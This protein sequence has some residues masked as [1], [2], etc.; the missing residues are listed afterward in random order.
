MPLIRK[1]RFK[2]IEELPLFEGDPTTLDGVAVSGSTPVRGAFNDLYVKISDEYREYVD[3]EVGDVNTNISEQ[4]QNLIN[5]INDLQVEIGDVNTN[6]SEQNQNLINAIND[7][8]VEIDAQIQEIENETIGGLQDQITNLEVNTIPNVISTIDNVENNIIP[9]IQQQFTGSINSTNSIVDEITSNIVPNIEQSV[10]DIDT[11]IDNA[12]AQTTQDLIDVNTELDSIDTTLTNLGTAQSNLQT[13]AEDAQTKADNLIVQQGQLQDDLNEADNLI[14]QAILD[15]EDVEDRVVITEAGITELEDRILLQVSELEQVNTGTQRTVRNQSSE[16]KVLK[17]LISFQ[18]EDITID[19]IAQT[20][21]EQRS[22]LTLT[23]QQ[24]AT[25]VEQNDY[26]V[27][28]GTVSQQQT[29]ILQ[30]AQQIALRATKSELNETVAGVLDSLQPAVRFQFLNSDEGFTANDISLTTNISTLSV[31][32]TGSNPYIEKTG[33]NIDAEE[34]P[35]FILRVRQLAGSGFGIKYEFQVSGTW[36]EVPVTEPVDPSEWNTLVVTLLDNEDYNGT[37]TGIRI[38]FDNDTDNE[39][40]LDFFE[41][42]KRS[43]ETL[44][45]EGIGAQITSL[46]SELSIQADAINARVTQATFNILDQTV[47]DQQGEINV[48]KDAVNI[49]VTGSFAN[50]ITGDVQK[51]ASEINILNSEITLRVTEDEFNGYTQ[52]VASDIAQI[53]I[54]AGS[55]ESTVQTLNSDPDA[56]NQFSSIQQTSALIRNEIA[57]TENVEV[58]EGTV[59][60][61]SGDRLTFSDV[62]NNFTPSSGYNLR[63]GDSVRFQFEDEGQLRSVFRVVDEVVS[64]TQIKVNMALPNGLSNGDDYIASTQSILSATIWEQTDEGFRSIAADV[65]DSFSQITQES[66]RISQVVSL[67]DGNEDNGNITSLARIDNLGD[68]IDLTVARLDSSTLITGTTSNRGSSFIRDNTKNFDNDVYPGDNLRITSDGFEQVRTVASVDGDRINI[69]GTFSPSLSQNVQYEVGSTSAVAASGLNVTADGLKLFTRLLD[70]GEGLENYAFLELLNDEI[71]QTVSVLTGEGEVDKFAN[72]NLTADRAATTVAKLNN[73]G[74]P[75]QFSAITSLIDEINLTVAELEQGSVSTSSVLSITNKQITQTVQRLNSDPSGEE[76]FTAI[77]QTADGI[78]Q[79][80]SRLNNTLIY[81]GTG[82]VSGRLLLDNSANFLGDYQLQKGDVIRLLGEITTGEEPNEVVEEIRDYK[83]IESVTPTTITVSTNFNQNLQGKTVQYF[84]STPSVVNATAFEQTDEFLRLTAFQTGESIAEILIDVYSINSTVTTINE[85]T[86]PTLSSNVEQLSG[87]ITQTVA[88]LDSQT[89]VEG[90]TAAHTVNTITIP[91]AS[92]VQDGDYISVTYTDGED[93][94]NQVKVVSSFEE[95]VL[96]VDS[97]FSPALQGTVSFRVIRSV[98]GA[99]SFVTQQ[100]DSIQLSVTEQIKDLEDDLD[101][102]PDE[103]EDLTDHPFASFRITADYVNTIVGG[104]GGLQSQ[105]TQNRN[106]IDQR[107]SEQFDIAQGTVSGL[108]GN[109]TIVS[110]TGA[111]FEENQEVKTN[112]I[113]I[114]DGVRKTITGVI[115]Q[116]VVQISSPFTTSPVGQ[117]FEIVRSE[118]LSAMTQSVFGFNFLADAFKH[119]NDAWG[120]FGDGEVFFAGLDEEG[121]PKEVK[122]VVFNPDGGGHVAGGKFNWDAQGNVT[123]TSFNATGI[124]VDGEENTTLGNWKADDDKLSSGLMQL[125][126]GNN[127]RMAIINSRD[128]NILSIND[129]DEFTLGNDPEIIAIDSTKTTLTE[130]GPSLLEPRREFFKTN[131][132]NQQVYAQLNRAIFTP[133]DY[134]DNDTL[135]LNFVIRVD[136]LF[137]ETATSSFNPTEV[138]TPE[139]STH[140]AV[141]LTFE[142]VDW[143]SYNG[144]RFTQGSNGKTT[145]SIFNLPDTFQPQEMFIGISNKKANT[146]IDFESPLFNIINTV[147]YNEFTRGNV[148]IRRVADSLELNLKGLNIIRGERSFRISDVAV[149]TELPIIYKNQQLSGAGNGFDQR[150]LV[151]INGNYYYIP[152]LT[153]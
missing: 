47:T 81:E 142:N 114:V 121:N 139:S 69:V 57:R 61:I 151:E 30:N 51:N 59:T 83:V 132:G 130:V 28:A 85:N 94:I 141:W 26:D 92:E 13:I 17:D 105:I 73:L 6:V 91:D 101:W 87:Q 15:L 42:G 103:G 60:N 71:N 34:N 10:Q 138:S 124:H 72:F 56:N 62:N 41:I 11:K 108:S 145:V 36:Y 131:G 93:T 95:N 3:D 90:T 54:N 4:N 55:I 67:L 27:L 39:Y 48:L 127:P 135:R 18:V 140:N 46:E 111:T 137:T 117:S 70:E 104:E 75:E 20:L 68:E 66:N 96:T 88:E 144:R 113:L 53:S 31:D 122:G 136:K 35:V 109:D 82:Q 29:E 107:I 38:Y 106:S 128:E 116:N 65:N 99:A 52:D 134:E 74:D 25:K 98:V 23:A 100:V 102:E 133:L 32:V 24:I 21:S 110:F 43:P 50:L 7:L 79:A 22:S 45:I 63:K 33:L 16:I 78:L 44:L 5:E 152:L 84:A 125:F 58:F 123:A 97:N 64:S 9:Q 126:G 115:N 86:L 148:V 76:Q 49:N 150:M 77:K 143:V 119:S 149:E 37:L 118:T 80:A 146:T 40:V 129:K 12:V 120:L 147:Y 14:A 2:R 1:D 8:Q 19:T 112:D 89:V 153:A